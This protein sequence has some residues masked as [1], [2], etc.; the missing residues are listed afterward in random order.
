MVERVVV[1]CDVAD[2]GGHAGV[3]H[4]GL[5]RKERRGKDRAGEQNPGGDEAANL[6]SV[7]ERSLRSGEQL[8]SACAE[9]ASGG[10]RCADRLLCSAPRCIGDGEVW[11]VETGVVEGGVDAADDVSVL[12]IGVPSVHRW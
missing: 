10:D 1:R 12:L 9:L 8:R 4:R 11:S 3:A 2:T 7:E 6:E 5:R